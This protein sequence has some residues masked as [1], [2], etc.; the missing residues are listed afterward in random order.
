MSSVSICRSVHPVCGSWKTSDPYPVPRQY[1]TEIQLNKATSFDT[2]P[3][4]L[5]LDLPI[6][7]VIVLSKI[8]DKRDDFNF[9]IVNFT[10]LDGDNPRSPSYGV[11]ILQFIRFARAC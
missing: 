11:N 5:D 8:Y 4:F 2:E 10:F 6:M 3:P 7:N 9:E 1:T